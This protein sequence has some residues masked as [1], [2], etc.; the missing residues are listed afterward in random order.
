VEELELIK[1]GVMPI[2]NQQLES[3]IS[4]L[5]S[6]PALANP[7]VIQMRAAIDQIGAIFLVD[8]ES[9]CDPVRA[10]SVNAEWVHRRQ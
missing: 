6:G 10:G 3:I 5:R 8:P 1:I 2:S 4:L 9:R 7:D